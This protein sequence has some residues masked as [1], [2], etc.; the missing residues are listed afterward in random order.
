M[1][2]SVPKRRWEFTILVILHTY[3]PMKM[4]E[5]VPKRRWEFTVILHTYSPMKMEQC[6]ETSLRILKPS[7]SSYLSAYKDG[8]VFRN[9][10]ENSQT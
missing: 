4:E 7:H 1:E 10:A 5:S 3:S 8:T 6:S 9:V 2:Q